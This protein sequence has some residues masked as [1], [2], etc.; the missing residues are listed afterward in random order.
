MD[1]E[2]TLALAQDL[3]ADYADV[4]V[5]TVEEQ[6]ITVQD[7][8]M[9]DLVAGAETGFGLRVLLNGAWGFASSN[10]LRPAAL[11]EAA[12]TAVTLAKVTEFEDFVLHPETDA[13]LRAFPAARYVTDATGIERASA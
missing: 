3:G 4:R 9:R 8:E 5:E 6:K 13:S 12:E 11:R 7:G 2:A 1:F 10:D